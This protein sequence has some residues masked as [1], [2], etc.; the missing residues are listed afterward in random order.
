MLSMMYFLTPSVGWAVPLVWP[1]ALAVAGALGYKACTS[2]DDGALLRGDINHELNNL[3]TV[4]L[5]LENMVKQ[6]VA[7]EVGREQVLRFKRDKTVLVLKRNSRGHFAIEVSGPRAMTAHSL[8]VA[9][10][11]FAQEL[12]Q[13]FACNR[14][15]RELERKGAHVVGEEVN[16]NGD[17]VLKLRRWD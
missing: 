13:Q 3:R 15:A 10:M 2:V 11:E 4:Q 8:Q 16:E 12:V 9:G 14:M 5:P 17:I 1:L 7:D 6:M